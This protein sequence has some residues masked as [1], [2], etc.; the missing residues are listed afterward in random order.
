M[1]EIMKTVLC[2]NFNIYIII[3]LVQYIMN[4]FFSEIA[5]I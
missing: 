2:N 1:A 4:G 5:D 3:D